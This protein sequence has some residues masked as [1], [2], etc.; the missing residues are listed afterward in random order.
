MEISES[1]VFNQHTNWQL[2]ELTLAET[3]KNKIKKAK[4]LT[5]IWCFFFSEKA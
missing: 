4:R 5:F 2:H 3:P 1:D